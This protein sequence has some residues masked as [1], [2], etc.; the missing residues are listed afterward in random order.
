MTPWILVGLV[1]LALVTRGTGSRLSRHFTERQL[2]VTNTGIQNQL[3]TMFRPNL[4]K[5]AQTL[6]V[7]YDASGGIAVTSAYRSPA[8]N[9]VAADADFIRRVVPCQDWI[10]R[11]LKLNPDSVPIVTK[12]NPSSSAN[13]VPLPIPAEG[14]L[15]VDPA[16]P[17]P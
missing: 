10:L 1:G 8:V 14:R 17:G 3:A 4:R 7:I 6:D 16:R 5:L 13:R 11:T 12:L 15:L 9:E 2:T